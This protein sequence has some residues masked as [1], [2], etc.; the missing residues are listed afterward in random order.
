MTPLPPNFWWRVHGEHLR[1]EPTALLRTSV[2]TM[3]SDVQYEY[4]IYKRFSHLSFSCDQTPWYD[5]IL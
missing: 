2:V 5:I 1:F 3:H 4:G